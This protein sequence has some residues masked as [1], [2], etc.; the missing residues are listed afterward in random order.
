MQREFQEFFSFFL[1]LHQKKW[2]TFYHVYDNKIFNTRVKNFCY[3][4]V[5]SW[6]PHPLTQIHLTKWKVGPNLHDVKII[7]EAQIRMFAIPSFFHSRPSTVTYRQPRRTRDFFIFS[8]SH[9]IY[10]TFI[11]SQSRDFEKPSFVA[12]YREEILIYILPFLFL[13]DG[14]GY[15]LIKEL[16]LFSYENSYSYNKFSS[17]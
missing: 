10:E 2:T 7:F 8:R 16:N 1:F 6:I 14:F 5:I 17:R 12:R 9:P 13:R 11:R 3:L 15:S 4:S